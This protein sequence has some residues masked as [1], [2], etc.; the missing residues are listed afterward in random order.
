MLTYYQLDPKEQASEIRIK[1]NTFE[2]VVDKMV[3]IYSGPSCVD[4]Q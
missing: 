1:Q 4:V 2:N 3:T